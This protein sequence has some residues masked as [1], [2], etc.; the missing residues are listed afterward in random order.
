M[1]KLM[2]FFLGLIPFIS[3]F[4]MNDII[5]QNP[6]ITIPYKLI[7]IIFILFWAF[8]GFI[9]CKF[10]KTSLESAVIANL[11]AF[12]VLL[13]NLYQEII[14]GEYWLNIFGSATQFYYLPLINLSSAF[15]FWS[16]YFWTVYIA[17]FILMFAS[18]YIGAYLKKRSK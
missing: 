10:G 8:I 18:Y 1:K 16:P 2:L 11:P 13:L 7:G 17:G 15:T 5:M 9:T 12:L 4:I 3:G 14:S 6:N